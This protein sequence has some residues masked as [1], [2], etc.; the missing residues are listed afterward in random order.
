VFGC[1]EGPLVVAGL[2]ASLPAEHA[3][4]GWS[5]D[6]Y[7]R[8]RWEEGEASSSSFHSISSSWAP[9]SPLSYRASQ[10]G[11]VVGSAMYEMAL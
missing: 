10:S 1:W 6:R 4:V 11:A 5:K 8:G 9:D 3:R 7:G 2:V